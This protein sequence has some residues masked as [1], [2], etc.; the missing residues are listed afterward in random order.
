MVLVGVCSYLGSRPDSAMKD[1]MTAFVKL[2]GESF[3]VMISLE[4]IQLIN[5]LYRLVSGTEMASSA[6]WAT[7][8]AIAPVTR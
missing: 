8:S 3:L 1:R 2:N 7:L 4:L 5:Y 6:R